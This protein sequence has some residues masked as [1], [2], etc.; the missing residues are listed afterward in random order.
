MTVEGASS[1]AARVAESVA[2]GAAGAALAGLLGW[3]IHPVVA[4]VVAR[5][6]LLNGLISGWRGIYSWR[7]REGWV[8]FVLDSTWATLPIVLSLIAHLLAAA[9][10]TGNLDPSL[11]LRQNRHVYRGGRA[12]EAPVRVDA[13]QCDLE[14]P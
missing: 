8:A 9:T 1:P 5:I 4:W 13:G 7:R 10:R 6:A 2:T 12:A 3:L 14:R 11:S